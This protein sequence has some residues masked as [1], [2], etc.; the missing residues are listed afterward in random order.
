M[1][2]L[3]TFDAFVSAPDALAKAQAKRERKAA[4]VPQITAEQVKDMVA[5]RNDGELDYWLD[6]DELAA[7]IN[8]PF[9]SF[10]LC[11]EEPKHAGHTII[12]DENGVPS[13][14]E[15]VDTF[16]QFNRLVFNQESK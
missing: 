10:C 12:M 13:L 2:K 16:V 15:Q 11:G 6:F 14:G 5:D 4:V 9:Q 7:L 1:P 8:E 3:F